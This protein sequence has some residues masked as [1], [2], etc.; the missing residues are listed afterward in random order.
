MS[1]ARALLL[2]PFAGVMLALAALETPLEVVLQFLGLGDD[3]RRVAPIVATGLATGA[4]LVF[5]VV[6]F[7]MM[8]NYRRAERVGPYVEALRPFAAEFGRGVLETKNGV[9]LHLQR[10]SQRVVV[11]VDVGDGGR[12]SVESPP[13]ARQQ[14]AWVREGAPPP[15]A[16]RQWREV[17]R[18]AR[19]QL[20]AELPAMARPL[21]A[22]PA[23]MDVVNRYFDLPE[24]A[25]VTHTISGMRV[26]GALPP[27]ERADALV[28]LGTEIAF[29][30]RRVN[31]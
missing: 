13:P 17:D 14:L 16:A 1:N 19:W 28:R 25:S 5:V 6:W 24:G 18:A 15:E 30:L 27:P 3:A 11:R 20:R 8:G 26:D 9:E 10:E 12:V 29:R 31:G 23:L 2:L 21:L 22:D 4:F 7:V